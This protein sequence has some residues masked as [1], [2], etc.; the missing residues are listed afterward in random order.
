LL[1]KFV[2]MQLI[3]CNKSSFLVVR[4][5]VNSDASELSVPL[6]LDRVTGAPIF[7]TNKYIVICFPLIKNC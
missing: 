7:L 6:L 5:V 4:D 1:M 3:C 2:V